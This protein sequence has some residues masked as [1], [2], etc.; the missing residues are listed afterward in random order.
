ME[1]IPQNVYDDPKCGRDAFCL[2]LC[3]RVLVAKGF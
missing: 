1:F 2:A 3:P